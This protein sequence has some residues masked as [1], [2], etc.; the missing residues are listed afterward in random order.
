[1]FIS[2]KICN[3]SRVSFYMFI[4]PVFNLFGQVPVKV[5][6]TMQT[7]VNGVLKSSDN[8]RNVCFGNLEQ[9]LSTRIDVNTHG[10]FV[11]LTL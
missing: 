5:F 3:T 1:M 2:I 7:V 9:L 11:R 8:N 4:E 10:L 6:G